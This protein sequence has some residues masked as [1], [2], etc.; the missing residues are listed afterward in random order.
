MQ[1]DVNFMPLALQVAQRDFI[2]LTE[3]A[4]RGGAA[5]ERVDF[6][7]AGGT[8]FDGRENQFQLLDDDAFDFE[9]LVLVLGSKLLVVGEG[10]ELVE[11]FPALQIV[12]HLLDEVGQF[13]VAHR[14]SALGLLG[15]V[16]GV[17]GARKIKA[18]P[19]NSRAEIFRLP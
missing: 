12:F 19:R 15:G 3:V 18:P 16:R 1:A 11:L 7:L 2:H 5:D 8:N 13:L 4:Q 6:L 14:A 10:H 17:W 9:E